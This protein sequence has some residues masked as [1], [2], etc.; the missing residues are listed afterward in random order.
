[1]FFYKIN[2]QI[3]EIREVIYER[4]GG[5]YTNEQSLKAIKAIIKKYK[6]K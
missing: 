5:N 3:N 6:T 1:M 4:D 2:D